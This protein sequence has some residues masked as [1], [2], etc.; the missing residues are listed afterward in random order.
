MELG[1]KTHTFNSY[2]EAVMLRFAVLPKHSAKPNVVHRVGRLGQA[3]GEGQLLDT[4]A[5]LVIEET[6]DGV[7]LIRYA[8]DG[9]FAGDTWH[10]SV[11]EAESD[12]SSEYGPVKWEETAAPANLD[13]FLRT[14][15]AAAHRTNR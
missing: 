7:F 14:T 2:L 5:L 6:P 11:P 10:S 12:A 4:A 13:E 9:A 1:S 8:A 15:L 3:P